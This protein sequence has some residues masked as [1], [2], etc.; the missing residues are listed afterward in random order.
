MAS[1]V[2][3]RS[4]GEANGRDGR[5]LSLEFQPEAGHRKEDEEKA[6]QIARQEM[7]KM[8]WGRIVDE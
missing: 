1:S 7:G 2:Y 6:S 3:A 8:G 4:R 5:F